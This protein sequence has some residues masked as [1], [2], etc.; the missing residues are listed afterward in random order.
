[1]F[2]LVSLMFLRKSE[3][4]TA[5]FTMMATG[6]KRYLQLGPTLLETV[7]VSRVECTCHEPHIPFSHTPCEQL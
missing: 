7:A 2:T 4:D 6:H 3:R 1:M 5:F